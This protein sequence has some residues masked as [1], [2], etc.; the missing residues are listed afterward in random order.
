[1][2]FAAFTL[3]VLV[4]LSLAA[5]AT[6][7]RRPGPGVTI[8]AAPR[9]VVFGRTTTLSGNV[10]TRRINERLALLAQPCGQTAFRQLT[11][12]FTASG[13]RW[14]VGTP[15]L[16]RTAYQARFRRGTSA[17]VTV[18][19]RPSVTLTRLGIGRFR[20]RV[21][22]AHSFAGKVAIFQRY[23]TSVRRWVRTRRVRLADEG[24]GVGPTVISS[25]EFSSRLPSRTRVRV[26]LGQRQVGACYLPG[27][28]NVIRS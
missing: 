24:T 23:R 20:V 25:A 7:A 16:V 8:K 14:T 10:S 15:P 3:S 26:L 12:T 17:T 21:R 27:R 4:A 13:G 9:V 1:M 6:A 5:L 2:K 18:G 19:V 28:S 11:T 22:A